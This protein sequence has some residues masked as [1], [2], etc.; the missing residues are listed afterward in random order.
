MINLLQRRSVR[1]AAIVVWLVSLA[2]MWFGIPWLTLIVVVLFYVFLIG[3]FEY[4]C[5]RLQRRRDVREN[6]RRILEERKEK[7]VE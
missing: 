5:Q 6:M 7:E 1:F 3:I 2:A 4:E